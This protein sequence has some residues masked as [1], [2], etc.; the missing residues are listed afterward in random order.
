MNCTLCKSPL[1]KQIHVENSHRF[2]ECESCFAIVRGKESFLNKEAELQRYQC[3]NNDVDD[4]RYQQFVSPITKSIVTDFLPQ[5]TLGLDFGAGTGP[6]IT[7]MLNQKGYQLN[8]YD[9]FFHPNPAA[10]NCTYDYIICCEVIEHFYNPHNEFQMLKKLLKPH[11]KLYCMTDIYKHHTPFSKWY[12]KNDPTHVIF[13]TPK[14]LQ[15][16][17]QN[18]GFQKLNITNRLIVFN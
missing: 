6:V 9:P 17:Q 13:Y 1:Q 11:G 2:F 4:P 16:I 5:N 12:Y 10:L 15:W 14:S 18:I 3:H 7:K 8:L